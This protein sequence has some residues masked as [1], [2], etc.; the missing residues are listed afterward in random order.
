MSIVRIVDPETEKP[1]GALLTDCLD[2]RSR[3]VFKDLRTPLPEHPVHHVTI[4]LPIL[5]NI[6]TVR[7]NLFLNVPDEGIDR[8]L[9][10][11]VHG[12]P[13]Q[14]YWRPIGTGTE[15]ATPSVVVV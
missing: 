1:V 2:N 8:I 15:D 6:E 5:S 14:V 10:D 7:D 9:D 12:L 4:R 11:R 3:R 13:K